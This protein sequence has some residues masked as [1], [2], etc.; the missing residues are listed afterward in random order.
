M[1]PPLQVRAP[2]TLGD[3]VFVCGDH[4]DTASIQ[5]ALVSGQRAAEAV[6][7]HL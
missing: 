1:T 4:R 7:A 5:G 3:G 6:N 2:V